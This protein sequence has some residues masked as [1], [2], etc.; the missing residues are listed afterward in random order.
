[1][2]PVSV[3][4]VTKNEEA[5]IAHSLPPLV[6]A[7]DE[8]IVVDSKSTDKTAKLAKEMGATVK[9]FE[10]NGQ[11]PKKRQWCLETLKLKHDWVFMI[12]ADEIVTEAFIAELEQCDYTE[13][14]YFIKSDMVWK[15]R[16]LKYGMK[17]NKLC[18]FKKSAFYYPVV[19]DLDFEGMGEVEGHYQPIP[20]GRTASIGQIKSPV[21]HHNHKDN[22]QARHDNYAAWEIAMNKR[23]AWPIDPVFNREMIKDTLRLSPMKPYLFFFYGYIVKAG[24]L[25]GRE[26]L[27]Y[28]IQRFRY[29]RRIVR[30]VRQTNG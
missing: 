8:V 11:Y 5:N 16:H 25:D 12:D 2:I 27:D 23:N 20:T 21:I 17:N 9:K 14:S 6:K 18:L 15:G 29:N 13:D 30:A 26:G 7:F 10:W 3:I 19:D 1:M 28:A 24:F 4:M 22:W